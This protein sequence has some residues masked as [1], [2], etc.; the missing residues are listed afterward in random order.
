LEIERKFLLKRLPSRLVGM[1]PFNIRQ[2][3]IPGETIHERVR[4]TMQPDGIA[5]YTRTIKYGEGLVRLELEDEIDK[6]LFDARWSLT[7]QARIHKE[8]Y[9]LDGWEVDD[10][11]DRHLVIAE[12]E[13]SSREE[14][15]SIP[16]WIYTVLDREVTDD[17]SFSNRALALPY[18]K[19]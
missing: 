10:F 4:R 6:C 11:R 12:F 16:D 13:M 15:I 18:N 14:T 3:W 1:T 7:T 17:P 9:K 8:R 5:V 2:G 19:P